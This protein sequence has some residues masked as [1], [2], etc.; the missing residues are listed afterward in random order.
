MSMQISVYT[1]L[2]ECK[3]IEKKL[4]RALAEDITPALVGKA[5]ENKVILDNRKV[6][7]LTEYL[8]AENAKLQSINDLKLRLKRIKAQIAV[9]NMNTIQVAGKEY[10]VFEALM[11]KSDKEVRAQRT[12]FNNLKSEYNNAV[13]KYNKKL[14]EVEREAYDASMQFLKSI[15]NVTPSA[16]DVKV[17]AETNIPT[18]QIPEVAIACYKQ[19]LEERKPLFYEIKPNFKEWLDKEED[20][21]ERFLTEV[22]TAITEFNMKTMIEIED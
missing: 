9:A 14:Q 1:A 5:N 20:D 2:R 11:L 7:D 18:E 3:L 15:G 8:N 12:Y 21:F 6:M 22:D 13:V 4:D 10:T 17:A 16:M 19:I